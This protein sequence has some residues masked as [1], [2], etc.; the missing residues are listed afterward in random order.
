[1][2]ECLTLPDGYGRTRFIPMLDGFTGRERLGILGL[3]VT[4]KVLHQSTHDLEDIKRARDFL[5]AW[6]SRMEDQQ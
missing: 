2:S 3:G 5:D 6:I 4:D 1:M